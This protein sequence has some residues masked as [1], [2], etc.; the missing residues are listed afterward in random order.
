MFESRI[1]EP[2]LRTGIGTDTLGPTVILV[3]KWNSPTKKERRERA[4]YTVFGMGEAI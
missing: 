2:V 4:D 3:L 1:A